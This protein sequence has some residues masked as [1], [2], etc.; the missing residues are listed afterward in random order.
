MKTLSSIIFVSCFAFHLNADPLTNGQTVAWSAGVRGGI[1]FYPQAVS[2]ADYGA[3]N[4][5]AS[6]SYGAFTNA[7]ANCTNGGAVYVPPGTYRIDSIINPAVTKKIVL[8]GQSPTNTVLEMRTTS[9]SLH[10]AITFGGDTSRNSPMVTN[11]Y[12]AGSS[13]LVVTSTSGISVGHLALLRQ[14]NDAAYVFGTLSDANNLWQGQMARV[15]AV[16]GNTVTLDRPLYFSYGPTSIMDFRCYSKSAEYCG[17]ENLTIKGGV[18]NTTPQNLVAFFIAQ[19]C[20][21]TNCNVTNSHFSN[22][23]MNQSYAIEVRASRLENHQAYDSNTRYGAQ[24]DY[25]STDCLI[26]DNIV[27][28]HNLSIVCQQGACGNVISANFALYGFGNGYPTDAGAKGWI[29]MH[30]DNANFNL[31]EHNVAPAGGADCFWGSNRKNTFH[32]NHFMRW[33]YV[34]PPP[35]NTVMQLGM[36][37]ISLEATN[38]H[39]NF[40]GNIWGTPRDTG[41]ANSSHYALNIGYDS[42]QGNEYP[43]A[44]KDTNSLYTATFIGNYDFQTNGTHWPNGVVALESSY[45]RA[46]KP[47]WFGSLAWPPIGPDVNTNNTITNSAVIPAQARFLGQDYTI[48]FVTNSARSTRLRGWRGL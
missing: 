44:P 46:S 42:R 6:D 48:I 37:A 1:P 43:A 45:H 11:G 38:Y 29:T 20:W 31:V 47:S 7:I 9:S 15:H 39:H 34:S 18:S 23:E 26:E 10:G 32:R 13:N 41:D 36:Y 2:V 4:T 16:S 33:G 40:V 17:L 12:T 14:S 35:T 28:G 27:N 5:G 25:W 24:M 3:D 30:G 22:V 19:N 21:I 8:R